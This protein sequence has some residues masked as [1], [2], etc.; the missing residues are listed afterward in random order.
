M[1]IKT[2]LL[3][4]K[5]YRTILTNELHYNEIKVIN[6]EIKREY[7]NYPNSIRNYIYNQ[8]ITLN[9]HLLVNDGNKYMKVVKK[10]NYLNGTCDTLEIEIVDENL[11]VLYQNK[12]NNNTKKRKKKR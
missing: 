10:G 1:N 2:K 7:N 8:T 3:L 4:P 5:E 11:N 12:E 9:Y 6:L